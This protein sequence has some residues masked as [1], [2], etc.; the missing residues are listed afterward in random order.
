MIKTNEY[1]SGKVKSLGFKDQVGEASVGVILPG[2]YEFNTATTELMTVVS[3]NLKVKLASKEEW[4]I[5]LAGQAFEVAA[6]SS[7]KVVATEATTYLC[8]YY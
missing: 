8:R 2:E 6:S 1:F 3:G 7:F 4:Q 5:Y